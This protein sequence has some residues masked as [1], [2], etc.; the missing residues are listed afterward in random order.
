M[1]LIYTS[2]LFPA[3]LALAGD[4]RTLESGAEP[5]VE[6]LYNQ[7]IP[8]YSTRGLPAGVLKPWQFI[9]SAACTA[10]HCCCRAVYVAVCLAAVGSG[11]AGFRACSSSCRADVAPF[12]RTVW[13]TWHLT[14][15]LESFKTPIF[16]ENVQTSGFG[17]LGVCCILAGS[18]PRFKTQIIENRSLL[19][20][21][22]ANNVR[23]TEVLAHDLKLKSPK[24]E[25]F[26]SG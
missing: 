26:I 23:T 3:G 25:L 11:V 21:I 16:S 9:T 12:G 14:T 17:P 19:R 2:G 20:I 6:K 1:Y 7:P 10:V 5:P 22:C 24:I 18:R 8:A 15:A 4:H 13:E